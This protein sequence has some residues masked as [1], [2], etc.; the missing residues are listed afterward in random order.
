MNNEKFYKAVVAAKNYFMVEGFPQSGWELKQLIRNKK[1]EDVALATGIVAVV[2]AGVVNEE[3]VGYVFYIPATRDALECIPDSRKVLRGRK[4]LELYMY[5]F[6][7]GT[8][9]Y[10]S[11]G[12]F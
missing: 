3:Y 8:A 9:H 10:E 4:K 5:G 7:Q 11:I 2:M 6:R 12:R 1:K